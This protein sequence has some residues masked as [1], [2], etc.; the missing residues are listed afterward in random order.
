ML[1]QL[2]TVKSR[3][4]LELFDPTDDVLITNIIKHVSG[5]FSL[6]CNRIFDYAAD[7]TYEF[8][9]DHTN[10]VVD[11]PP[12][13]SVSLFHLK[14]TEAEGWLLQSDIDYLLLPRRAVIELAEPLGTC[15]Q[16][17]R[18]TYSGGFVLPGAT[19]VGS[20]VALPDELE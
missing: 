10:L 13:E 18:T 19:P 11:R 4:G 12:I 3:L 1:T 5:R 2:S 17:G 6:E 9:A 20:Q 15:R 14:S 8:P 7:L 16:F